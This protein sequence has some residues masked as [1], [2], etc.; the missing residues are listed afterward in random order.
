M[1]EE[2]RKSMILDHYGLV[3]HVAR[4]LWTERW[5]MNDLVQEGFVGLIKAVD[6][7]DSNGVTFSTYAYRRIS[8]SILDYKRKFT[9]IVAGNTRTA[10]R[11]KHAEVSIE[12][13]A[14][15]EKFYDVKLDLFDLMELVRR[16]KGRK[17]EVMEL[18]LEGWSSKEIGKMLGIGHCT[19][20]THKHVAMTYLMWFVKKESKYVNA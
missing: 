7:H 14:W 9:F 5:D 3:V 12:S 10:F 15:K 13:D 6:K 4:K 11:D 8:G 1:D 18:V 17:K 20:N 19:V 2:A 16:L